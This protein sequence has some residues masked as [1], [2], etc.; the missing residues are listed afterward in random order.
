MPADDAATRF[1]NRVADYVR[2]RPSY[3]PETVDFVLSATQLASTCSIADVGSGTGI[4]AELFL[5][6]GC[7]VI[8]V[9]PN[10]DM[11]AAAETQLADYPLFRSVAGSAEATTLPAESVDLVIA[12]QAFHWFDVP[13]TRAEFARI[14]RAPHWCALLWNTLRL[15]SAPFMQAYEA[16]RV[17][18][19]IDYTHVRHE[20]I[21][22]QKLREFFVPGTY[23]GAKFD[24]AQ[25]LD[26][27]G[28]IGRLASSSY[29]PSVGHPRYAAMVAAARDI[30]STHQQ[31]G[32]VA[33]EYD[34]EVHLGRVSL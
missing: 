8:G 29:L 27:D 32:R 26:V 17:E 14:T 28:L 16:L 10:A 9:E 20:N 21:D 31:A 33:L 19:G 5:R 7:P 13:K 3:P 12:A 4:S 25:L 1:S 24:N 34:A 2:Y 22:S 30:F 15:D 6:R 18:F 11:R 23:R